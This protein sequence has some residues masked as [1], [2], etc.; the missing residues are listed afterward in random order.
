VVEVDGAGHGA[1]M[2]HPVEVASMVHRALD[3]ITY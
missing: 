1:H 2:T 3:R